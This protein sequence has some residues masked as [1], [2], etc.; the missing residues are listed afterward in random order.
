[1]IADELL[2]SQL[3]AFSYSDRVPEKLE[4]AESQSCSIA[5]FSED[6]QQI[7]E[8][9]L[10]VRAMEATPDRKKTARLAKNT[11]YVDDL[12]FPAMWRQVKTLT[13][14]IFDHNL[15]VYSLTVNL[16]NQNN[17]AQYKLARSIAVHIADNV[18]D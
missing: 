16:R 10:I 4:G 2:A 5:L 6:G 18:E 1:V 14:L 15:H 11:N 12:P 9:R 17:E 13:T 8:V 7:G 3:P